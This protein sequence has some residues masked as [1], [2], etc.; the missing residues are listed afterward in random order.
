MKEL[1]KL[2]TPSSKSN[3]NQFEFLQ[4][5]KS[6]NIFWGGERKIIVLTTLIFTG[7]F[8]FLKNNIFCNVRTKRVHEKYFKLKALAYYI[9]N[10]ASSVSLAT[11]YL[12]V[13]TSFWMYVRIIFPLFC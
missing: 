3:Y 6:I 2:Q 11:L 8:L 13:N 5:Y 4:T 10:S 1:I 9:P 7:F 12:S